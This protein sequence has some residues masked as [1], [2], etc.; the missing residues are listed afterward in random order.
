MIRSSIKEII[1]DLKEKKM[2]IILDDEDRENEGDL[3]CAAEAVTPDIVNFMAMNG[4]GLICLALNAEKCDE[5][6]L[7]P[8][9]NN[10]N[11]ANTEG[12]AVFLCRAN[13]TNIS[14]CKQIHLE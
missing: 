9:T 1:N 7:P 6:N 13:H 3:I 8:M 4:R 12:T 11:A 10:N 14:V 5:L 2:V